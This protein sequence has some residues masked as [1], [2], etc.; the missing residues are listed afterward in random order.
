MKRDETPELHKLSESGLVLNIQYFTLVIN[1]LLM[2]YS[3]T[4]PYLMLNDH[5]HNHE[6][7]THYDTHIPAK[8]RENR[9]M[10]DRH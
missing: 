3:D 5:D 8:L 4:C 9:G 6:H 7:D 10:C 2:D 1:R